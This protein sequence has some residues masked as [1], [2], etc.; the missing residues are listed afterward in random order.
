[1]AKKRIS[2]VEL[3]KFRGATTV[4]GIDFDTTKPVVV[5]F[6]E[7]GSGKSTLG[8]AL[9]FVCNKSKGS[10]EAMSSTNHAHIVSIGNNASELKVRVFQGATVWEGSQD[11]RIIRVTPADDIPKV[12]TL[13]RSKLLKLVEATPSE[14]FNTIKAFID[15]D[16]IAASEQKLRDAAKKSKANVERYAGLLA[17]ARGSLE[18]LWASNGRVGESAKEW[19][20]AKL[21][22]DL[23]SARNSITSFDESIKSIEIFES[24]RRASASSLDELTATE[25]ELNQSRAAVGPAGG[26]AETD[27]S[28]VEILNKVQS[29]ISEP[30]DRNQCPACLSEFDLL[31]LRAEIQERIDSLVS[32]R[33]LS[34]QIR[35]KSAT[36]AT[37]KAIHERTLKKL[38]ESV[39]KLGDSVGAILPDPRALTDVLSRLGN[40]DLEGEGFSGADL[41][42][43]GGILTAAKSLFLE[44]REELNRNITLHDAIKTTLDLVERN[45]L[46]VEE[47]DLIAKRLQKALDI[48]HGTRISL[49]QNILDAV[50]DDFLRYWEAIHPGEPIKPTRLALS[51]SAKGSLNQLGSFAGHDDIPPQAY[52]SESHL[53]TLG[54]CYWLAIAKYSSKG[55]TIVVLDDVFTSVDSEHI[56]RIIDLLNGEAEH[57]HQIIITTHQRRWHDSYRFGVRARD[58]AVVLELDRWDPVR[59]IVTYPSRMEIDRLEEL[60]AA[61]PFDRQSICSKAGVL[62]EQAFDEITKLYRCS[63]PRGP[64]NEYTLSDY[65]NAV[66]KLF[67]QLK[68]KRPD[69]AGTD[70]ELLF[71]RVFDGLVPFVTVRNQVGAHFNLTAAEYSDADITKFGN[72]TV[73]LI[74]GLI[75]RNCLGMALRENRHTGEWACGCKETRMF[76]KSL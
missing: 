62:L 65:V 52:F 73:S 48:V 27:V 3:E 11:G 33:E 9:D 37:Q 59:G 17:Q 67:T 20:S 47:E 18:S 70:E 39:G 46:E 30:Y 23:T 66:K 74:R 6:G 16:N 49:T 60:L 29:F 25:A 1:M 54:F 51:E 43:L 32:A 71:Q 40:V 15:F 55:D 61:G 38:Q 2:R 76:P 14:R 50:F 31:R 5:I 34:E 35:L 12:S 44:K 21:G 7:N 63:M 42:E 53:D 28:L 64:R 41:D 22:V 69:G 26:I 68:I 58:K 56:D 8:N 24:S 13:R 19:A 75:C 72:L 4:T 57:F 10:L 36:V 45:E